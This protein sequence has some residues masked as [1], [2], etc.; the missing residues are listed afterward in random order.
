MKKNIFNLSSYK[1]KKKEKD[2]GKIK[3]VLP[4]RTKQTQERGEKVVRLRKLIDEIGE[5]LLKL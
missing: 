1:K 5:I 3:E 4:K 2:L